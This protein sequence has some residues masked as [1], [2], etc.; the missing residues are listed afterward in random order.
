MSAKGTKVNTKMVE[1]YNP[2]IHQPWAK[3]FF[4]KK[5]QRVFHPYLKLNATFGPSD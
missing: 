1:D 4:I 2:R 3:G 5:N